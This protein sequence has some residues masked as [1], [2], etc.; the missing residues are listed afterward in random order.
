MYIYIYLYNGPILIYVKFSKNTN[1]PII[2]CQVFKKWLDPDNFMLV[3]QK[4]K[5]LI[6]CHKSFL[7]VNVNGWITQW[8]P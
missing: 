2:L 6:L 4:T 8:I 1:A 3:K 5:R 7:N